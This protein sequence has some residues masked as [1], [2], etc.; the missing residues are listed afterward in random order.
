MFSALDLA[1]SASAARSRRRVGD[2]DK[3]SGE[4]EEKARET[5][6][7]SQRDTG[8]GPRPGAAEL[9]SSTAG[10]VP[11]RATTESDFA[12]A[13][14]SLD[15]SLPRLNESPIGHDQDDDDEQLVDGDE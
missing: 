4:S 6:T 10:A 7:G 3:G 9:R 5:G 11:Q 8:P 2:V 15:D 1:A 13:L 14:A 12:S